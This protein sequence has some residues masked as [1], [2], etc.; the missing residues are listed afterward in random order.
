MIK[1][2]EEDFIAIAL[3]SNS[4]S[5][6]SQKLGLHFNTFKRYA[7]KYNCWKP[8]QGGKGKKSNYPNKNKIPLNEILDGKHPCYQT[9]KLNLRLLQENIKERRC[10]V[11]GLTHWNNLPIPIELHHKDGNRNNH[12]LD[13]LMFI[14]PN[15]HAQTSTYRSKNIK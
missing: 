11:C 15:C 4:M 14:C 7:I 9:Y 2:N 8:N 5:E 13:N 12:K 3:N 1:I 6:A 10:E